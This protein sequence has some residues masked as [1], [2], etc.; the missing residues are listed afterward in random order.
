[1]RKPWNKWDDA[2]YDA[3]WLRRIRDGAMRML[4]TTLP[5]GCLLS[6]LSQSANG[7]PQS[8]YRQR[9]IRVHRQLFQIV[10]KV[11]LTPD[12]DVCHACDTR[13]CI[14]ETHLWA[15]T[16][17]QNMEDCSAKGRAD[18]QWKTH[19]WR[20]H[21]YTPENTYIAPGG[22]LR[23]CKVCSRVRM[24]L[25]LGWSE[26]DAMSI[27]KVPSGYTKTGSVVIVDTMKSR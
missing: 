21:E 23:H 11:K 8:C 17:K 26:Q 18:G 13:H 20:G 24:R 25:R 3:R 2:E 7:Y 12:I 10:N 27:D 1:M 16:R 15:G 6:P 5:V 22:R 9:T 14:E 19:C 4:A